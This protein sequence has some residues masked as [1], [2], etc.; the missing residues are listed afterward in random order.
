MNTGPMVDRYADEVWYNS[1]F[2]SLIIIDTLLHS[3]IVGN[4]TPYVLPVP[5]GATH[6]ADKHSF[7]INGFFLKYPNTIMNP[8][9]SPIFSISSFVALLEDLSSNLSFPYGLNSLTRVLSAIKKYAI[10]GNSGV[11]HAKSV[12]NNVR[13]NHAGIS[14]ITDI[15]PLVNMF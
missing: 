6:S 7:I 8:L 10:I 9:N 5:G 13:V 2:G 11:I 4:T 12:R 3:K 1:G 14:A 15:P